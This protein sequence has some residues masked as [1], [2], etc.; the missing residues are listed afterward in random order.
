MKPAVPVG[1]TRNRTRG[2][3]GL[4]SSWRRGAKGGIPISLNRQTPSIQ[5]YLKVLLE[6]SAGEK[7]VLSTDIAQTLGYSRA[8]VC[9]AMNVL[10]AG[11]YITKEKYGPVMLT[12][13]GREA[14]LSVRKRHDLLMA[15]LVDVLG[16]EK[17]A[18]ESDACRMEHAVSRETAEK[19]ER[20]LDAYTQEKS[21]MPGRR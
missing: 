10:Q 11:G 1:E 8:S 17:A 5:D 3:A 9:R 18:A 12:A 7:P 14:A 4:P 19:L 20:F 13:H 2:I 16:V 6:L 15:F 21:V